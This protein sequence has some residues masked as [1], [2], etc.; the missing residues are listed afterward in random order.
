MKPRKSATNEA[1]T[2]ES[3]PEK[4]KRQFPIRK[5][6]DRI[7]PKLSLPPEINL[8]SVTPIINEGSVAT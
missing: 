1:K 4:T 2:V 5:L 6:E 8:K 3:R 7:A